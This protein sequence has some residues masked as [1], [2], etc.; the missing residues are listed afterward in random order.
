[1]SNPKT[2]EDFLFYLGTHV[3]SWLWRSPDPVPFF[4]SRRTLSK[5]KTWKP[6]KN[7]WALDSGGF[8]EIHMHGRWDM[9]EKEYVS[10]VD[11]AR[12]EVGN[13]D[14]AAPQDWMCE[15]SALK[16]TGLSVREHQRRTTLNFLRL[17]DTKV[18]DLVI[19]VLQGQTIG[20]YLSHV[21]EYE[22]EGISLVEEKTVGVGSVCRR[23]AEAEF[24]ELEELA[25]LRNLHGFGVKKGGLRAQPDLFASS[26]SLAWSFAARRGQIR[27][28]GHSHKNCA[29]CL[30][31]ALLWRKELLQ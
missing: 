22:R 3:P 23:K 13:L 27:L 25:F 11:R 31:F 4:V 19:P 30:E 28:D 16:A 1:M 7:R 9:S 18:G 17:R 15:D 24:L 12:K 6:A 2:R 29:N 10:F 8:T 21:E 14:F 20:D 5:V 26:D